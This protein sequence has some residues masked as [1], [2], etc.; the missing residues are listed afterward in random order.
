MS[1]GL[2]ILLLASGLQNP[3]A[4]TD[5]LTGRIE[6]QEVP[7][8]VLGKART[9]RVWLPPGYEENPRRR[10]PVLFMGDGQNCFSGLTSYIPNE[11]WRADEAAQSLIEAGLVEPLIIA[12]VD[13]GGADRGNEYLPIEISMR[14]GE[15]FGGRAP[16]FARFLA[17]EVRPWLAKTYRVDLKPERTG[18]AGS[19]FG[20][21][22]A[23]HLAQSRRDVWRRFGVFSPSLWVGNGEMIRRTKTAD[24][25]G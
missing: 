24:L 15:K 17:E 12:A 23:L 7:S 13:N 1:L 25:S 6:V 22:F 8:Q 10:Y 3:P 18:F 14:A 9:V 19:S 2:S 21:V 16:V 20:G 5:S 4:R 11:E